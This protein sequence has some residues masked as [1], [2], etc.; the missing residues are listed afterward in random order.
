M[1]LALIVS[2]FGAELHDNEYNQACVTIRHYDDNG[3][4]TGHYL[5]VCH[6]TARGEYYWTSSHTRGHRLRVNCSSAPLPLARA[7]EYSGS[8]DAFTSVVIPV[9]TNLSVTASGTTYNYTHGAA[10][11]ASLVPADRSL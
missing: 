7:R 9:C 8:E 5:T 10:L 11:A 3:I 4:A 2:I 6:M 1:P